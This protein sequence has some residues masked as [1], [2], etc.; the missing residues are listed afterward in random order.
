MCLSYCKPPT[1]GLPQPCSGDVQCGFGLVLLG[2]RQHGVPE[3]NRSLRTKA[4]WLSTGRLTKACGK[5]RAI[6]LCVNPT[7]LKSGIIGAADSLLCPAST[8]MSGTGPAPGVPLRLLLVVLQISRSL[9]TQPAGRQ[10]HD[11]TA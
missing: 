3:V 10:R 7:E 2:S 5:P 8:V 1:T 4:E 9:S 6:L 11:T